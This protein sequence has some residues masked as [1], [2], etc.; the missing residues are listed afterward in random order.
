MHIVIVGS[1]K[2]KALASSIMV[3]TKNKIHDL[4]GKIT[5]NQFAALAEQSS[6]YLGIDTA[7]F[8]IAWTLG[9]PT[10]GIFGGGHFGR[11]TPSLPHVRII[12]HKMDCYNCYWHC[13]YDGT[14]C[15]TSI[16]P[17]NVITAIDQL[18]RK[19]NKI[20]RG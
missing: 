18:L 13:I 2:D 6:L 8:H 14:K 20:V 3:N 19:N 5:L 1:E 9:I 11:F 7:G 16:T 12:H 10:I 4:T 17:E 15:I